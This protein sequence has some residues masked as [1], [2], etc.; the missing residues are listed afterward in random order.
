M[1]CFYVDLELRESWDYDSSG[2]SRKYTFEFNRDW[3]TETSPGDYADAV[4]A[5]LFS[6]KMP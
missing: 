1:S 4:W 6:V 2:T 5:I 3:P